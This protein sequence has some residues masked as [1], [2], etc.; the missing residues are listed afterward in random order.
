MKGKLEEELASFQSNIVHLPEGGAG[1][2]LS[3]EQDGLYLV[4]VNLEQDETNRAPN[5]YQ[6][7]VGEKVYAVKPDIHLNVYIL[8]VA[9]YNDYLGNLNALGKVISFFQQH[10]VFRIDIQQL[11]NKVDSKGKPLAEQHTID[12][13]HVDIVT[14]P[15]AQ[16]NE[17]WNA[18]RTHY[19]PSVL[20]KL[21]MVVFRQPVSEELPWV[22][23][24]EIGLQPP[25]RFWFEKGASELKMSI[26]EEAVLDYI[27]G[28]L[29]KDDLRKQWFENGTPDKEI[30]KIKKE[31]VKHY[32][33]K[34]K[35]ET[36]KTE[37]GYIQISIP[38]AEA[39]VLARPP[40][41][42]TNG[43]TQ[44]N[45]KSLL[46]EISELEKGRKD[47][48]NSF[49]QECFKEQ[50]M[51]VKFVEP[52]TPLTKEVGVELYWIQPQEK[53]AKQP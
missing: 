29:N 33:S 10:R 21:R 41:S 18:L 4:I 11:S 42:T 9:S 35:D 51:Q 1:E 19:R 6:R 25:P 53:P 17:V 43:R 40:K 50:Q 26:K 46:N 22:K 38:S 12:K 30:E 49:F 24:L 3:F 8:I 44:I 45:R 34:K 32:L 14:L 20:L 23:Q 47:A 28:Q 15:F 48:V 16:Q 31:A 13:L 36:L 5:P 52:P 27:N 7:R 2:S 39:E 37:E